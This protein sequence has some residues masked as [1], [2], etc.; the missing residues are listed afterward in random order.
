MRSEP[1]LPLVASAIAAVDPAG[2]A[3]AAET[4][5][6]AG[7]AGSSSLPIIV[8]V[9]IAAMIVVVLIASRVR[10]AHLVI[11]FGTTVA[12]WALGYVAM[13]APGL[14]AGEVL[15]CL[16][17][18]CVGA[19]GY[20]A[21][22]RG[23]TP[24]SGLAVGLVSA[25]VNLLVVGSLFGGRPSV[26][27]EVERGAQTLRLPLFVPAGDASDSAE[28]LGLRLEFDADA[29]TLPRVVEVSPRGSAHD[30]GVLAGDRVRR[31]DGREIPD[32]VAFAG[33][34]IEG[35]AERARS[36]TEWLV[37]IAGLFVISGG[38]GWF[39]G[40]MGRRRNGEPLREP[41][42][43]FAIVTSAAVMLLL[44]TGGLV[45]GLEA[46]LAV[47]DWPNS[48]GH[49]MLLYPMSE[50]KGGIYYE[51]AHR[52][53]GMLV[54]LTVL[55]LV[56]VVFRCDRRPSVRALACQLLI[57]VIVQGLLG[58]MRVTGEI[59]MSQ[60]R[61]DHAP[62]IAL[63]VVHGVVGQAIFAAALLLAGMLAASWKQPAPP[64][65]IPGGGT[66]RIFS[67]ALLLLLVVQLA[68][69]ACYRHLTIPPQGEF[70]GSSPTWAL[71]LHITLA[72]VIMVV[73]LLA[74]F[75]A[76]ALGRDERVPIVPAL[77]RALHIAVGVQILLG[78]AAFVAVSIRRGP[79]IP[80]WEVVV[81]TAHQAT[82]AILLGLATLLMAWTHR[83][84]RE[85]DASPGGAA[86]TPR[87]A[88]PA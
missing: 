84:V 1:A 20:V 24:A 31:L 38:L 80:A 14:P 11:G 45:T 23:G 82:G 18:L 69:G 13:T 8:A 48:F 88:A 39:G 49:N 64:R 76:K 44:T 52:L 47:P 87:P 2:A 40:F 36:R 75:R 63:A 56:T 71:H 19:G 70:P 27:I 7:A 46:G 34:A 62:N 25:A 73:A 65:A 12:M 15:F 21:A 78:I 67:G 50:M 28:L 74:G 32:A 4:A 26:A 66:M 37:W 16:M 33:V 60:H 41:A 10:V 17:L 51:H 29:R 61:A 30:A 42:M 68:I 81:T 43:L 85:V 72:A 83:L 79:E 55:V 22:Q 54:G 77:G 9:A 59:S 3:G 5:G 53:F 57:A 58:A 86:I 35:R 6:A